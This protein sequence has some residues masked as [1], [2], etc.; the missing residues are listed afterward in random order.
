MAAPFLLLDVIMALE[1]YLVR[2][3]SR[4]IFN[5]LSLK[6]LYFIKIVGEIILIMVY[7]SYAVELSIILFH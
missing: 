4:D 1:D 5:V 2:K 6:L 7:L 3:Q